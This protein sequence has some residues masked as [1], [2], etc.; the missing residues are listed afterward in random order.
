VIGARRAARWTL[1]APRP[2]D[3][4]ALTATADEGF[5]GYHAFAPASYVP[6]SPAETRE[7]IADRLT[8]PGAF[9]RCAR[10]R[11]GPLGHV[12]AFPMPGEPGLQHLFHLFLRE[13][14]H[15]T[16]LATALLELAVADAREAG[17]DAMR[18]FTPAG[19]A[20]ARAFYAREGFGLAGGPAWEPRLGMAVVELRRDLT[21]A[22]PQPAPD[23]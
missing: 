15:G 9:A 22:S 16:G 19:Q 4:A 20:R 1:R 21:S 10:D 17:A 12:I 13:R 11:R 18:L 3:L 2:R 5:R 6:P 8:L 7:T 23:R 14:A